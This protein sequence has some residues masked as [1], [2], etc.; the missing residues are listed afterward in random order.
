MAVTH[1]TAAVAHVRFEGRSLDFPLAE[2]GVGP[3]SPDRE[4]KRAVARQLEVPEVRL[5]RYVIDRH[6]SGNVTVRPQ[7][8]FG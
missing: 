5:H 1:K 4:V 2:L 3:L 7:A 8:V 6:E